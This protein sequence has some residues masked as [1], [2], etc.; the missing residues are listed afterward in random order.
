MAEA[1]NAAARHGREQEDAK[2]PKARTAPQHGKISRL[3]LINGQDDL[4]VDIT[5]GYG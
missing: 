3:W 1:C 2:G 5:G 4:K